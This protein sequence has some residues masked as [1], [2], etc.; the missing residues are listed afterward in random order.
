[1]GQ[2]TELTAEYILKNRRAHYTSELSGEEAASIPAPTPKEIR[3]SLAVQFAR[4]CDAGL[5]NRLT[6]PV[7]EPPN[8]FDATAAAPPPPGSGRGWQPHPDL[9]CPGGLFQFSSEV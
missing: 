1:V 5:W 7:L 3:K 2:E 9:S 8:P 4:G 6:G